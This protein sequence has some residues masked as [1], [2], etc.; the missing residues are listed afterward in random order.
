MFSAFLQDYIDE[1]SAAQYAGNGAELPGHGRVVVPQPT[2]TL[3]PMMRGRGPEPLPTRP[4]M[5]P[6]LPVRP[7]F[8]A[9]YAPPG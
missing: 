1:E 8:R 5:P 2:P 9:P 4:P 7:G 3:S 6:P